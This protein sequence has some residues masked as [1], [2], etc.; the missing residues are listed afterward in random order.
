MTRQKLGQR[1]HARDFVAQ[2]AEL[3]VEDPV[4]QRLDP[5]LERHPPVLIP[6][7]TRVGEPRP[8]H[9]FVAGDDRLPAIGRE[10]V[11]DEQKAR[12]RACRQERRQEKYFWCARIAVASTSGGRS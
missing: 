2:A 8:Q 5:G 12:G 11:G 4:F 7:E 10:I 9:P 1:F 6:K 3:G